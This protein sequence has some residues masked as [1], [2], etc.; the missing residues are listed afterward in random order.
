MIKTFNRRLLEKIII[1]I[2]VAL[3]FWFVDTYLVKAMST[4]LFVPGE[5]ATESLY[6]DSTL[7]STQKFYSKFKVFGDM[8]FS[9]IYSTQQSYGKSFNYRLNISL[10]TSTLRNYDTVT[11][12]TGTSYG[13]INAARL[14]TVSGGTTS[15]FFDCQ[16]LSLPGEDTMLSPSFSS[17][18]CS[19]DRELLKGTITNLN[20]LTY[21]S[22]NF[23]TSSNA[24]TPIAPYIYTSAHFTLSI[25]GDT[26]ISDAIKEETDAINKQTQQQHEDSEKIHDS[27]TSSD[28]TDANNSANSFFDSFDDSDYGLS[29]VITMP[30]N[31]IKK[32][33]SSVCTPLELPLPFVKQSAKLP[34][35]SEV[36]SKFGSI[37]K[38]YQTITFGI[39][40]YWVV[41]NT[42][43]T[44]RKFKDPDSDE[45]EVV[46]L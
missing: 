19:Y 1:S 21:T 37:L 27:I 8:G 4:T 3:T 24:V 43:A 32:M 39:V 45:I 15:P 18:T 40:S 7:L 22:T 46:A 20:I 17:F 9:S 14:F 2:A 33:T 26:S 16:A 11:F 44:I 6:E 25:K 36:Y 41:V 34:C 5:N 31:S 35:M 13:V 42:F 29:D 30:L 10:N 12:L 28:T 38:L 23:V